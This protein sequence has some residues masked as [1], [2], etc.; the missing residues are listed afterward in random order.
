[1]THTESQTDTETPPRFIK[2]FAIT[3]FALFAVMAG[4]ALARETG[5]LAPDLG[6]RLAA[7]TIG[8][9]LA[10]C[11]NVLP[12]FARSLDEGRELAAA[13]AKA[14]RAAGSVLVLAGFAFSA[15]WLLAPIERATLGASLVGLAGFFLALAAWLWFVRSTPQYRSARKL[16]VKGVA[17]RLT[18]LMLIGSLAFVSLIFQVDAIWGDQAAQGLAIFGSIAIPAVAVIFAFVAKGAGKRA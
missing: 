11:G 2:P 5:L 3:F 17:G 10:L 6:K 4:A 7:A 14:D 12:K 8:V 1:M 16:T 9:M 18:L 15:I 13:F